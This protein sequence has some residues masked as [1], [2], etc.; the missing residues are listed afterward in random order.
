MI[1]RSFLKWAGG[2]AKIADKIS[3]ALPKARVLVEPFVGGGSVFMNTDYEYYILSDINPDL[4]SLYRMLKYV[5]AD[6]FIKDLERH[7]FTPEQNTQA[8]FLKWRDEFNTTSDIYKK[9]LIFVYLNRHGFNGLCRY[10]KSGVFNVSFGSYKSPYLPEAEIRAFEEKMA[11]IEL[12]CWSYEWAFEFASSDSV[13]YCDPPYVP[14]SSTAKFTNYSAEGFSA[15]DQV[16]LAEMAMASTVPVVISNHDTSVTRSLYQ[17]AVINAFDV[18]RN[19]SQNG[20]NRGKA[21]ELIAIFMPGQ[22]SG[23]SGNLEAA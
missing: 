16:K 8:Q 11:R 17:T 4:I 12:H 9:A 1:Q 19:I 18:Q 5:G 3:A 20:Q 15:D 23:N 13:I 14:L 6:K 21:K 10:N 2:K 22:L 7:L